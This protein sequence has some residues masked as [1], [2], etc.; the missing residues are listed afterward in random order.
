MPSLRDKAHDG[1]LC[2]FSTRTSATAAGIDRHSQL[3]SPRPTGQ[4]AVH[5]EKSLF[6]LASRQKI[7]V[8]RTENPTVDTK[9]I[10]LLPIQFF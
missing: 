10:C 9:T 8:L 5:C 2:T 1:G 7:F 4:T 3:S 6:V